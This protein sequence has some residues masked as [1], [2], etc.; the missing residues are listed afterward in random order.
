MRDSG[1]LFWV[2]T[3]QFFLFSLMRALVLLFLVRSH[4]V[5]CL[6][7]AAMKVCSTC[8][9]ILLYRVLLCMYTVYGILDLQQLF[10]SPNNFLHYKHAIITSGGGVT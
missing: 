7:Y 6:Q 8:K 4:F 3:K 9:E 2:F 10:D 1:M 5:W